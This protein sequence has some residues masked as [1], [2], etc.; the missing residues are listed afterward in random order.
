VVK[1][2]SG[3][4]VDKFSVDAPY[5]IPDANLPVVQASAITYT[6]PVSLPPG[7]YTV[8]TAVVDREGGRSAVN[9]FR[10]KVPSRRKVSA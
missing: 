5:P 4:I 2:A 10:W 9:V 3:T 6:H 1:E 7:H 8:E